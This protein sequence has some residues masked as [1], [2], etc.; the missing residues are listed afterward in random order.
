MGVV[1]RLMSAMVEKISTR[2]NVAIWKVERGFSIFT[3][4]LHEQGG[5]R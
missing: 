3:L 2:R 4:I 1:L 5:I